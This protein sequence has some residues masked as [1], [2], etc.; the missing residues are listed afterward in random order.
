MSAQISKRHERDAC[1]KERLAESAVEARRSATADAVPPQCLNGFLVNLFIG[2]ESGKVGTR[3]VDSLLARLVERER[4]LGVVRVLPGRREQDF[5]SRTGRAEDDGRVQGDRSR[6]GQERLGLPFVHE[7]VNLLQNKQS[8][9][10]KSVQRSFSTA[11]AE[12][13]RTLSESLTKFLPEVSPFV[14]PLR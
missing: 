2:G 3:E 7:F 12:G 8:G 6:R 1:T 13:K 10:N 14:R 4:V 11:A 5:G 9:A